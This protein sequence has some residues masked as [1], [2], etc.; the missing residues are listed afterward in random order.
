[1]RRSSSG[2]VLPAQGLQVATRLEGLKRSRSL[3]QLSPQA[4]ASGTSEWSSGG[5]AYIAG[6]PLARP[7]SKAGLRL[8]W[9]LE[10]RPHELMQ[11]VQHELDFVAGDR[12]FPSDYPR[13]GPGGGEEP[14]VLAVAG[15]ASGRPSGPRVGEPDVSRE[16]SVETRAICSAQRFQGEEESRQWQAI[17]WSCDGAGKHSWSDKPPGTIDDGEGEEEGSPYLLTTMSRDPYE[18]GQRVC[19]EDV[20]YAWA[21][22][23]CYMSHPMMMGNMK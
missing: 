12:S 19:R 23:E 6:V 21:M 10:N 20:I 13:P 1:M 11:S 17:K 4:H 16:S 22:A 2:A 3:A 8:Q 7:V 15:G 18:D 14:P 5:R 9:M